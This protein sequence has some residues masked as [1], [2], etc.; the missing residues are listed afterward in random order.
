MAAGPKFLGKRVVLGVCGSIAAY[1]AVGLLRTLIR[2]GADVT[3]AMTAAATRF[4]TPLTFEVLSRHPVAMDLFAARDPLPHLTLAEAADLVVVAPATANLLAKAALGL[5]DDLLSTLLLAADRPLVLAPAMDG[6][7]WSHPAVQAHVAVL[8]SRGATV[9]EP[10]E[11]P[12]ASGK[13]GRGRLTDDA[14]IL[15]AIAAKLAPRL[16]WAGQRVLVSAG[17]TQEALDPVRF[18]S[19][20]SSGKMGYAIAQAARERGAEVVLVSGPTALP[21]PPGVEVVPVVTAEEMAK[22]LTTR[23]GWASVVI[24]AAAVADFR[25]AR[26]ASRKLMKTDQAWRHLDLEPTEDILE[27]LSRRKTAQ[28]LVGFAAETEALAARARDKLACKGLDLIVANDVTAEGCGFGSDTNAALLIDRDGHETVLSLMSK[29][30]LADRILDAAL[31]LRLAA[32]QRGRG[33]I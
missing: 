2:E 22:A 28:L 1:K 30:E 18:I 26:P 24:M 8:R 21:P 29:R 6:D 20:R 25:P 14:T 9:L 23:F 4:V 5:A 15:D 12:L 11:G 33:G 7:M 19:N 27:T 31:S 13:L 10:D 32:D 16:D 17:P 3:V